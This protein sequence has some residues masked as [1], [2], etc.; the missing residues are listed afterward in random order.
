MAYSCHVNDLPNEDAIEVF[1]VS[2]EEHGARYDTT[3]S[4]SMLL[5]NALAGFAAWCMNGV[6][7]VS[8]HY[9]IKNQEPRLRN[10]SESREQNFLRPT[11]TPV[12]MGEQKVAKKGTFLNVL[13]NVF[14]CTLSIWERN[15][16]IFFENFVSTIIAP[17][18]AKVCKISSPQ[19]WRSKSYGAEHQSIHVKHLF[20][21]QKENPLPPRTH[22]RSLQQTNSRVRPL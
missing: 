21:L 4:I 1:V 9:S 16:A 14:S 22:A 7:L 15:V 20:L 17:L 2:I 13:L 11:M 19:M 5:W 18:G 8:R 3:N 10:P 6:C 12:I